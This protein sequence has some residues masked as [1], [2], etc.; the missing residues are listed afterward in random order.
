M[1]A[2]HRTLVPIGGNF[3]VVIP[4]MLTEAAY[5]LKSAEMMKTLKILKINDPVEGEEF[6]QKYFAIVEARFGPGR[7]Y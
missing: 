2:S 6:Y 7:T 4:P 5:K 3:Q 1:N